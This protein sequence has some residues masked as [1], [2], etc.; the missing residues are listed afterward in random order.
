MRITNGLNVFIE[1]NVTSERY[2][3]NV[4]T[5]TNDRTVSLF[6]SLNVCLFYWR[7]GLNDLIVSLIYSQNYNQNNGVM[8]NNGKDN[9]Y[10][11][12]AGM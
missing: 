8:D 4:R 11:S 1:R 2:V 12:N 9:S 7:K 10:L 5:K 6:M 3:C